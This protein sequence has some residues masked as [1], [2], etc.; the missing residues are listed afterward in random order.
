MSST[1]IPVSESFRPARGSHELPQDVYPYKRLPAE[2]DKF[3]TPTTI[4]KGLL[5]RHKT[6]PTA[7]GQPHVA[8][9]KLGFKFLSETETSSEDE[10]IVMNQGEYMVIP[11]AVPHVVKPMSEDMQ[12]FVRFWKQKEEK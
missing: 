1:T 12:M 2:E 11:P 6:A 7:W 5:G 10:W 8:R 9:G 4:P 3:F